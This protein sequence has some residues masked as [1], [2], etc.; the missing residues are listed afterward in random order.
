MRDRAKGWRWR[1][2]PVPEAHLVGL[3]VGGALHT[4]MPRQGFAN[5]Q[6]F[7]IAGWTL[8]AAGILSG[9]W[10]VR[11]TGNTDIENPSELV[12]SGPFAFSRNPM[13]VAWT[14][15]YV[16]IAFVVNSSW[17][18]FLLPIVMAVT[19]ITVRRE[20]RSLERAFGDQYRD[21]KNEVRRYV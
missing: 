1:N 5:L 17:L 12:S 16:G 3:V 15:L 9:A 7:W 21:Y 6:L 8:I 2:V 10:A 13:Y 19:H 4:F 18:F 11:A 14:A 20:E